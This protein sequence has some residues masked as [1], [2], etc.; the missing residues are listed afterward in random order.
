MFVFS[1][2]SSSNEGSPKRRP[3]PQ[4]LQAAIIPVVTITRESINCNAEPRLSVEAA[5]RSDER[6]GSH[7]A[8]PTEL[9]F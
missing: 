2:S 1:I 4:G 6:R 7:L 3:R 5:G 8:S 9:V